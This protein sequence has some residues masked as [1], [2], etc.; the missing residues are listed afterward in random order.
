MITERPCMSPVALPG[1]WDLLSHARQAKTDRELAFLLVNQTMGLI[2]YRQAVL[3]LKEEGVFTLSGVVQIEANAPHV[4]WVNKVADFLSKH[5][6]QKPC[7]FTSQT[8]PEDLSREWADWWPAHALWIPSGLPCDRHAGA[9]LWIRQEAWSETEIQVLQEWSLAWWHDFQFRHDVQLNA[10]GSIRTHGAQWL[11]PKPDQPWHRQKRIHLMLLTLLVVLFPVRQSVLAPGELVP[12]KPVVI[13]SPLEGVIEK[14]HVQ[15]NQM[16]S[17]D[18]PL[19]SFDQSLID[20]RL[21][22]AEQALNTAQA[23]YRQTYQLALSDSKAK[24]ELALLAG[25]IEEKRAEHL[26]A[27][28]QRQRSVV[29]APQAGVVLMDDPIEWHGKPVTVGA[30]ILRIA[31]PGDIEVEAWVPLG[32]AIHFPDNA[33]V[34][35]YLNASPLSPV[36]AQLRYLAYDAVL[37]PDGQYAYRLRA[38]LSQPTQ[39]RVGLKGTA[40]IEGEWAPLIFAL[41]RRPLAS[42]R[43]F[44]GV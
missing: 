4:L 7:A 31:V 42:L 41:M 40:R 1:L 10:W 11:R 16:V 20:H 26:F 17:K 36:N 38:V 13:R 5:S 8:L 22:V 3:W 19:F 21:E 18:H 30:Q 2:P 37:R 28:E 44:L 6:S 32:D 24:A 27:A 29:V 43:T 39:H 34:S 14:F 15:P 23:D 33:T 9:S 25:K 35:L 12:A